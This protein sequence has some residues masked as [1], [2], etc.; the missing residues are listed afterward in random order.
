MSKVTIILMSGI[1]LSG[2]STTAETLLK[3]MS[4]ELGLDVIKYGTNVSTGGWNRQSMMNSVSYEVMQDIIENKHDYIIVDGNFMNYPERQEFM[5]MVSSIAD[6]CNEGADGNSL[7][8]VFVTI[9]HNRSNRFMFNANKNGE[10]E[11]YRERTL[12][13]LLN[14][15]QQPI[16]QEGFRLI[17]NVNG[18]RYINVELFS[19]CMA[20]FDDNFPIYEIIPDSNSNDDSVTVESD[21]S[22]TIEIE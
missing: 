6:R 16:K 14:T 21:M 4:G 1:P 2:R 10:R 7:E 15:Y 17:F 18:N 11:I 9:Q 12:L 3:W 22:N 8:I 20:K 13:E 19:R 5:T